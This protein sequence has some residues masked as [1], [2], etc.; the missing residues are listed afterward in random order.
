MWYV[1]EHF[2]DLDSVLKKVNEILKIG[3][4]FAFSTPCGEGVSGKSDIHNFYQISPADHYTIWEITRAAPILEKYGFAIKKIV[5]TGHHPE[6]FPIIKKTGAE[7]GSLLWKIV[8]KISHLRR[9]G[10]TVEIYCKKID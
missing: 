6:R 1:I 8:D 5:S 3:G 7:K 10:D 9:L 4:T 2:K